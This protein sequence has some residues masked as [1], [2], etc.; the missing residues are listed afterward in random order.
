MSNYSASIDAPLLT[1][2]N[3]NGVGGYNYGASV[4]EDESTLVHRRS[5]DVES[6]D[7]GFVNVEVSQHTASD[8]L[9]TCRW[10]CIKR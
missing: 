9:I 1:V 8:P 2:A 7:D 5:N 4:K 10:Y 3:D 6:K